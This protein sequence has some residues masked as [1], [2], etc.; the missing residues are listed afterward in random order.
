MTNYL[1]PKEQSSQTKVY[2][3]DID[4]SIT[5]QDLDD[6]LGDFGRIYCSKISMD[7][8]GMFGDYGFVQFEN[9]EDAQACLT[10]KGNI[11][12]NGMPLNIHR[13]YTASE[14]PDNKLQNN[15]YIRNLP[16][17]PKR[18][19]EQQFEFELERQLL[20]N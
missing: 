10:Q 12:V 9:E 18:Y 14:R 17:K 4:P 13:F 15:L 8:S 3:R 19:S 7:E 6:V 1:R 5:L 16:K 20:V 2:F 11:Y